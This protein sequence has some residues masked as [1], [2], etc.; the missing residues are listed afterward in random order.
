MAKFAQ[1]L[2]TETVENLGIIGD[3]VKVRSG[4]AR[5]YLL[6]FQMATNPTEEKIAALAARRAEVE[7]EMKKARAV[8]EALFAKVKGASIEI[9]RATNEQGH[10]FGG[11][12][13]HDIAENLRLAGFTGIEDRHVRTGEKMV[14]VDT[15]FVP[16]QLGKDLKTE[17]TVVVKSDRKL[18][19]EIAAEEAAERAAYEA[20]QAA[21]G[22]EKKKSKK[23]DKGEAAGE[24]V[25]EAKPVKAK[26]EK[27][28]K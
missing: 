23:A 4:Y 14:R 22:G 24:E 9:I 2:L 15:Y 25:A 20:K 12:S 5:N 27:A 10:L 26:K 11:V 16:L 19:S 13:Q 1:V 7:A 3:V 8:I 21:E 28:A 18:A 17:I 6:P